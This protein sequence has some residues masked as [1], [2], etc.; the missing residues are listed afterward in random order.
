MPSL[1][2]LT[3]RYLRD[4]A[5][6]H[7]GR[8]HSKLKTRDELLA[9]LRKV[10][11]GLAQEAPPTPAGD[12]RAVAPLNAAKVPPAEVIHF[13]KRVGSAAEKRVDDQ[14]LKV[15][16]PPAGS[17]APPPAGRAPAADRVE[18]AEAPRP[19]APEPTPPRR[20]ARSSAPNRRSPPPPPTPAEPVVE[21]FFVARVAGEDEVRRHH[22][23]AVHPPRESS[24]GAHVE[25]A[26]PPLPLRYD[27]DRVMLLARDPGTVFAC[28]D[29]SAQTRGAAARAELRLLEGEGILRAL[30]V[31]LDAPSWYL[32]GVPAGS[33]VRVA[34]FDTSSHPP[35]QLG[36]SSNTVTVPADDL[37][38]DTQARFMRVPWDVHLLRLRDRRDPASERAPEPLPEPLSLEVWREKWEPLAN[39]GSWQLRSWMERIPLPPPGAPKGEERPG[40]E[41]TT[42]PHPLG[43]SSSF[44][45][46]SSFG[47]GNPSSRSGS[48]RG[49][50]S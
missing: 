8:G 29:L 50:K 13:D 38:S 48:G 46:T 43:G 32:Q 1:K 35:R 34:L 47:W 36:P 5:R 14:R 41:L 25:E 17:A 15:M 44:T 31:P 33:T 40:G 28:W 9:A 18:R 19:A 39:S 42:R 37:S 20:P 2:N 6:K 45:L 22:L 4:L 10:V 21:G 30:E 12:G 3:V 49:G 11:P 23:S 27:E 7:L 24:S 16:P 26:L